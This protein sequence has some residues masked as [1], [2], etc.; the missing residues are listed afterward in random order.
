MIDGEL[1]V[2][3]ERDL[4]LHAG[5]IV[6]H[7]RLAAGSEDAPRRHRLELIVDGT[8]EVPDMGHAVL[9]VDGGVL[10]LHG[11]VDGVTWTTLA[12]TAQ[13][14]A[15]RLE[16]VEPVT[17]GRGDE[18]VVAATDLGPE[19]AERVTIAAVGR[20]NRCARRTALVH[21]LGSQ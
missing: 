7:G 2:A 9:G 16:L 4:V 11:A 5:A 12:R 10:D 14:G 6:V 3:D 15:D 19:H 13:A 8:Q 1:H 21:P 17:W 18:L 20:T